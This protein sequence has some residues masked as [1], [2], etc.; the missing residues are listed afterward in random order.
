MGYNIL[1]IIDKTINIA[2]KRKELYL[3]MGEKNSSN[4]AIKVISLVL[5]K[6]VDKSLKYYNELKKELGN[7]ELDEIDFYIYDKISFIIN[8]FYN[9]LHEIEVRNSKEFM[10][11]TLEH[12]KNTL[13]M[14]INIQGRFANNKSAL[15]TRTYEILSK[16]IKAKNE[17]IKMLES[18]LNKK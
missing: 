18:V 2:K 15:Q 12:E 14:F 8:E 9:G 17:H 13:S 10:K 11:F 16:V 1:D 4:N 6:E 7:N 3:S 5:A